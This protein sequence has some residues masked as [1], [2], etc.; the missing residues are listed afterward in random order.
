MSSNFGP[1]LKNDVKN[2]AKRTGLSESKAF[3][4]W[5]ATQILEM[6]DDNALEAASIDGANDKGMDFFHIN[7]E[8]SR[9]LIAQGKYSK[10]LKHR[11]KEAELTKLEGS[12]QW[13][14][15][16][17]SLERDGRLDLAQVA[18]D[19]RDGRLKGFSIEFFYVYAGP[20]DA[21]IEKRTSVYNQNPENIRERRSVRH[22]DIGLLKDYWD[23]IEMGRSRISG[24]SIEIS[25]EPLW[26][27]GNFGESIVA[28]VPCEALVELYR[29]HGD[30]LFDR[31]VRLFLGARQGS[32]NS[33]I[34]NTITSKKDRGN[35]WAYN[36]GIT[37]IC[38]KFEYLEKE[39]RIK[40]TNYSIVNGCQTTVS[41]AEHLDDEAGLTVLVKCIA[42]DASIV[43]NIIRFT[44][45][46]NQI[47]TWDLA[48]QDKVHRR[49]ATD[50]DKLNKPYIYQTRRGDLPTGDMKKY[51][52]NG[53]RR[54]VRIEQLGQ[55]LAAFKG[56]PVLAYKHKGFIFSPEQRNSI[57]PKDIRV[58]EA[59][60]SVLCGTACQKVVEDSLK[61]GDDTA[62]ILKKG[63]KFFVLAIL[64]AIAMERNGT[65]FLSRLKEGQISS[66]SAQKRLE[67]Y[68]KYA[69]SLYVTCVLDEQTNRTEELSTLIR[70]KEFFNKV[71]SRAMR[72]YERDSMGQTWLKDALPPMLPNK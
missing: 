32:V 63:G 57:F 49:L 37:I 59:L 41:L 46:Q 28:T 29:I 51:K 42:A 69:A 38:D 35:F 62:R 44:N 19:Y 27:S 71:K 66:I 7:D 18:K 68:A 64:A 72:M 50:F 43:D 13:L 4:F 1:T 15:S 23:E 16:P 30:R 33:G 8:E 26:N 6:D 5:F 61:K 31:N 17:E 67:K 56:D 55:L 48:S 45:S 12:V 34:A 70:Q 53:K 20:R 10:T 65:T 60:F 39:S 11:P 21:N 2:I 3:M 40:I 9:I 14:S 47:R 54:I 24:D 36:N 58:E 52:E 25:G 22:F